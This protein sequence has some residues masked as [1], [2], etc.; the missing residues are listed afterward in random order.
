[1]QRFPTLRVEPV[2][3]APRRAVWDVLVDF[4]RYPEW[5]PFTIGVGT[6]GRV[7]WVGPA[8]VESSEVGLSKST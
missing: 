2:I 1:M 5:N 7:G 6:T 3:P 8:R 4:A